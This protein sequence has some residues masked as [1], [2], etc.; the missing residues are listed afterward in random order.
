MNKSIDE[1]MQDQCILLNKIITKIII[2]QIQVCVQY[3][4]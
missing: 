1:I 2:F 4:I 3:K